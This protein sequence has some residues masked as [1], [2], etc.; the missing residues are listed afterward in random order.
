MTN[1]LRVRF[2]LPESGR[3]LETVIDR[4]LSWEENLRLISDISGIDGLHKKEVCDHEKMIFLK[5]EEK[6]SAYRIETYMTFY[7]Y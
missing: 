7:L 6:V 1:R 3:S 2:Y 5:K 4:R